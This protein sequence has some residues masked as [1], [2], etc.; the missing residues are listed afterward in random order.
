[1]ALIKSDRVLD[2]YLCFFG[3]QAIIQ[4]IGWLINTPPDH[5]CCSG[6]MRA[7]LV[8]VQSRKL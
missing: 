1:M 4:Q 5:K 6:T 8:E 7:L 3:L 2:V